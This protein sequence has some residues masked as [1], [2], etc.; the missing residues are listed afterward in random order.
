[1]GRAQIDL[2][3]PPWCTRPTNY[4][5][6]FAG[7]AGPS[8]ARTFLSQL[9]K[10]FGQPGRQLFKQLVEQLEGQRI[11]PTSDSS[12]TFGKV[13]PSLVINATAQ[14]GQAKASARA[15]PATMTGTK[16]EEGR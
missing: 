13:R 8:S 16:G 10:D 1:M 2:R 9:P 11:E 14:A 15:Y 4:A 12:Q 7:A 5:G 6:C 3:P